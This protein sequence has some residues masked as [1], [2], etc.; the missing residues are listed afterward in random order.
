M[1]NTNEIET[2]ASPQILS[3]TVLHSEMIHPSMLNASSFERVA[4]VDYK[5]NAKCKNK[6]LRLNLERKIP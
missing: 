1:E 4:V 2:S 3:K 6:L 5:P